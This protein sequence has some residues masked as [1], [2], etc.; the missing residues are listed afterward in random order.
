MKIP[1]KL[2]LTIRGSR[3]TGPRTSK[4]TSLGRAIRKRNSSTLIGRISTSKNGRNRTPTNRQY[5]Y[6]S[7]PRVSGTRGKL[8]AACRGSYKH[9]CQE[10]SQENGSSL[11]RSRQGAAV[12]RRRNQVGR[13]SRLNHSDSAAHVR[14]P[15]ACKCGA[16]YG[17]HCP[18][19]SWT[20]SS[21]LCAAR[22]WRP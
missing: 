21:A 4:R 13:A 9:P 20:A 3:P 2:R 16:I 22:P 6:K 10:S 5:R 8:R 15:P 18:G 14:E 7:V 11:A 19:A 1:A 17:D 12:A